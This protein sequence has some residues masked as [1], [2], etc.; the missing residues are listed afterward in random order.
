MANICQRR[1]HSC[2]CNILS[3]FLIATLNIPGNRVVL[4]GPWD[5]VQPLVEK[6]A[7][8]VNNDESYIYRVIV[9]T[10]NVSLFPFNSCGL[11]TYIYI[12][13]GITE[14]KQEWGA[15]PM[16]LDRAFYNK[17]KLFPVH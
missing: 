2:K 15:K 7:Q 11:P 6:L 1:L 14:I 17:A 13:I 10:Q 9:A 8:M 4:C 16:K 12:P 5:E 3:F